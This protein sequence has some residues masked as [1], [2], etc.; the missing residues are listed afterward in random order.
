MLQRG[1]S[2]DSM[3]HL[4]YSVLLVFTL[5]VVM[6]WTACHATGASTTGRPSETRIHRSL[7]R[8]CLSPSHPLTLLNLTANLDYP[9]VHSLSIIKS[10]RYYQARLFTPIHGTQY[11][12]LHRAIVIHQLIPSFHHSTRYQRPLTPFVPPNRVLSSA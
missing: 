4:V 6:V 2:H 7:P 8:G 9:P 10:R 1:R 5:S 3:V 12:A 11:L